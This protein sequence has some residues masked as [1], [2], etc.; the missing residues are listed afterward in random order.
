MG[1]VEATELGLHKTDVGDTLFVFSDRFVTWYPLSA[2]GYP[3]IHFE[4]VKT[5]I[6]RRFWQELY[7]ECE[8]KVLLKAVTVIGTR[9]NAMSLPEYNVKYV[10]CFRQLGV[11]FYENLC[12]SSASMPCSCTAQLFSASKQL[13]SLSTP[14]QSVHCNLPSTNK[15]SIIHCFLQL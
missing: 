1:I 3:R 14:R 5:Q 7:F 4:H 11:C 10:G 9:R 13:T 8:R 15:N 6:I 12:D 2:H